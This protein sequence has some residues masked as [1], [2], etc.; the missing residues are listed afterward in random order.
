MEDFEKIITVE[1]GKLSVYD[2]FDAELK[3]LDT[4]E[5]TGQCG[6]GFNASEAFANSN[7][8]SASPTITITQSTIWVYHG[9]Q[10]GGRITGTTLKGTGGTYNFSKP[11]QYN[12]QPGTYEHYVNGTIYNNGWI[13]SGICYK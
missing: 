9:Q 2:N 11:G 1:N 13:G 3:T 12:V 7:G 5:I 6:G 4:K 8:S 10:G